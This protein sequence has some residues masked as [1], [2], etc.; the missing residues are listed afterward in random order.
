MTS[1][2]WDEIFSNTTQGNFIWYSHNNYLV[3]ISKKHYFTQK[4]NLD[5]RT[6]QYTTTKIL[7]ESNNEDNESYEHHK[8]EK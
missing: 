2:V 6:T 5:S 8:N 7:T 4:L 3:K 1:Q